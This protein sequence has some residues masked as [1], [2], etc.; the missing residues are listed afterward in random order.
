[1]S[2][3]R[4]W[5]GMRS[6][7]SW[8]VPGEGPTRTGPHQV[9]VS[10]SQHR[11]AVFESGERTV[12]A[13]IAGGSVFVTGRDPITWIRILETTEALEIYPDPALLR[14]LGPGD[15]E[16]EP[17]AATRDGTVLAICSILKRVHAGGA[18]LT[19]IA[20]STL[21]HR[22]AG[23]MLAQYCHVRPAA[24]RAAGRLDR[25]RV[26]RVA[27]FVDAGLAGPLTLE[28]LAAVASLSPFHFARAFRAT[29]GLAP[30]QFV[31]ARRVHRA[32]TLLLR[33]SDGVPDIARA[34][35]LSNVSYFRRVFRRHMG[36]LPGDLRQN[37]K[38]G[39]SAGAAPR[40]SIGP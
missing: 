26:D 24:E 39:P 20:A 33:S 38:I 2:D 12:D 34:V 23:H 37:S 27:E 36:V 13:D 16:F 15:P 22:L 35:G 40:A 3:V 19:D 29:T 32:T 30:H 17:A 21:A 6:E 7:Y 8:I 1:V 4:H 28:R 31:M 25:A 14:T 11:A 9:G 5:P 18:E 10:F